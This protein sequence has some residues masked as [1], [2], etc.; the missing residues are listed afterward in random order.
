MFQVLKNEG[1][2]RRG[3][4]QL[5]H[6]IVETPV[7]MPVGTY[8]AVKTMAPDELE[9]LGSQIILGNTYHLYL[10][11][12]L[13][14]LK[15]LEGLHRMMNWKRPILTDSGG[16]QVFSLAK[17]KSL[18]DEGV[19]FQNHLN[20]DTVFLTP[21]LSAEIQQVIGSDIAMVLD[22]CV[23]LP[24]E[25]KTL[26]EA[27]ERSVKWAE[28]FLKVPRL[29]G[30][31][32]FGINQGGTDRELRLKSLKATVELGIDGVA[33]GGLSVGETHE[34]MVQVLKD[35]AP[36]L[37]SALPHYLMGV[38][39]PRDILEAV[40]QG[41]DMFDCVLPTRNARNGGFFTDDGLLNIRN[42]QY[43]LDENPIE[44]GCGCPTCQNY[45][46]A[47]LRHLFQTKEILGLRLATTH[48]LYYYHR[49]LKGIREAIEEGRFEALYAE[50]KPRL[51]R[52]Y[53]GLQK[54]IQEEVE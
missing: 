22:E 35:L 30:Q 44:P 13:E 42:S 31:K 40:R 4:L 20:G 11:P 7:F 50:W 12:G 15:K 41:V 53:S 2:A 5:L 1:F 19:K 51:E 24:N 26:N 47:Y 18:N 3:R 45:S 8:G 27:V 33:I 6:G 14:V 32:I 54:S 52:A 16:F 48:N 34:E 38:G 37:P 21:E 10:R 9:N 39:T 23:A 36:H 49:F 28:R 43:T 25:K 29:P 17:L 46:R